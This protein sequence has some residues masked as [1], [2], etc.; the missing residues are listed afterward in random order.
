MEIIDLTKISVYSLLANPSNFLSKNKEY[1]L[2]CENGIKS[3]KASEIL[4]K[5]GYNTFSLKKEIN[6]R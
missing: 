3:K 1:L 2:I 5:M 6:K 4:N